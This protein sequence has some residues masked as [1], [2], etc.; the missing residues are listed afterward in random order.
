MERRVAYWVLPAGVGPDDYETA[1]LEQRED[2]VDVPEPEDGL[3]L[4]V[5]DVQDA[6]RDMLPTGARPIGIRFLD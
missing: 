3:G 1:D 5:P 6:L 4:S 2:I